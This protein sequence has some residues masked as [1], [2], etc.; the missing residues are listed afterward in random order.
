MSLI[1][2]CQSAKAFCAQNKTDFCSEKRI[3]QLSNEEAIQLLKDF[4]V[5]ISKYQK[6]FQKQLTFENHEQNFDF[7]YFNLEIPIQNNNE[8]LFK[9]QHKT[10]KVRNKDAL[11][12]LVYI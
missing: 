8:F 1:G 12:E 9:I 4:S 11:N 6:S 10:S 3:A 2:N 5:F 7:Q